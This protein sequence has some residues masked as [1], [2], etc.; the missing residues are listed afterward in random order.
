[1]AGH[2]PIVVA[3]VIGQKPT[4]APGVNPVAVTVRS[5]ADVVLSGKDS[6]ST[7]AAIKTFGWTKTGGPDLPVA[8]DTGALLYRTANTVSFRAPLV[9]PGAPPL[10]FRL[11]VT[12]AHG[13][14][15]TADVSVTVIPPADQNRTLLRP[16]LLRTFTVAVLTGDG[17]TGKQLTDDA[18][19]CVQLNRTLNYM[20][21]TAGMTGANP[22]VPPI[23]L[24]PIQVDTAWKKGTKVVSAGADGSAAGPAAK[25]YSNPR[26]T[27]ELPVLNDEEIFARFNQPGSTNRPDL[28]LVPADIDSAQL[29]VSLS[30]TAG[31]CAAGSGSSSAAASS[32]L[33]VAL[34]GNTGDVVLQSPPT[35]GSTTLI[36]DANAKPLTAD[37]L[38][39]AT[40]PRQN[41]KI[42]GHDTSFSGT[43]VETSAS[44]D[45]YYQAIDPTGSKKTLTAWL[46]A[47]CF[48]PTAA[49]YGVSK[50]GAG[51]GAHA[52]YTNN[53]DLGFGRD[54]YFI[55]CA[56][57][58]ANSSG[59]TAHAGDMATVV[60]NYASLEQ[61]ALK[62][63]PILAVAMEYSASA[64]GT[65]STRRF[66]KFYAFAPDD[67]TGELIRVRSAN[68]DRRGQKYLPGSCT[69]CHAGSLPSLPIAFSGPT[70][71]P[72]SCSANTY[73]LN[74]CYPLIQDPLTL[75]G[76]Q[77]PAHACAA[78]SPPGTPGCLPP[79]DVDAAFLPW[80]LDSFLFSD[81]DPAFKGTLLPGGPYTRAAQEPNLKALNQLAHATFK[82]G[83][84][85]TGGD[86]VQSV[87]P[88]GGG[89]TLVDRYAAAKTL[90]EY[91]YG[92]VSFPK[93][94]YADYTDTSP[95]EGWA[96]QP[97]PLYHKVFARNCRTCHL[98][99]TDTRLQFSGLNKAGLEANKLHDGYQK[100]VEEF[101]PSN[102]G[103][104]GKA[105][106]YIFQQGTMPLARL[107]MDRF[108]VDFDSGTG[109]ASAG[110][111]LATA[112][113]QT[114][115]LLGQPA[116]N[117]VQQQQTGTTPLTPGSNGNAGNSTDAR[118]DASGSGF[119]AKYSWA[120]A[121]S[122][123][124][125]FSSAATPPVLPDCSSGKGTSPL[126]LV[127]DT[128]PTPGFRITKSGLYRAT[129]TP[130]NGVGQSGAQSS[131]EYDICVPN[132][133]PAWTPTNKLCNTTPAAPYQSMTSP[134]PMGL[135][136]SECFSG[137]GNPPYTLG[138][139]GTA[140]NFMPSA[141]GP[142]TAW[143][144]SV[145]CSNVISGAPCDQ[146]D[147]QFNLNPGADP[148]TPVP[149]YFQLC[150]VDGDCT[151]GDAVA[152][153]PATLNVIP[154]S[155]KILPAQLV[156]YWAPCMNPQT[157][158]PNGSTPR[159]T[160][161]ATVM[162]LLHVPA[163]AAPIQ[164]QHPKVLKTPASPSVPT[165]PATAL[166]GTLLNTKMVVV[167]AGTSTL[168]VTIG[169][170]D[171]T[172]LNSLTGIS[173]TGLSAPGNALAAAV[174]QIIYEPP[175]RYGN[176]PFLDTRPYVTSDINGNALA[177]PPTPIPF[178]YTLS[179]GAGG[180][181]ACNVD[182][183][184]GSST[185][186]ANSV[187]IRALVSFNRPQT[188]VTN[189]KVFEVL[190]SSCGGCHNSPTSNSWEVATD[191]PG[192]YTSICG[193]TVTCD[194]PPPAI[195]DPNA[196]IVV[197]GDPDNSPFYT[198]ACLGTDT[199]MNA[200][201]TTPLS[202]TS[203]ECQ[204]IYQWI[205]EGAPND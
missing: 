186:P 129:L 9:A 52:V 192:T 175:S 68:F 30:A 13:V 104:P 167:G 198:A 80:D 166:L 140:G 40:A 105:Q 123:L 139:S 50:A 126:P 108:W 121:V 148:H 64:D 164:T 65:A 3:T 11:T 130:D 84:D 69:A 1:T 10:T 120:L 26:A 27:F 100:I 98:A 24:P 163:N 29:Q 188:G 125:N 204:T 60:I 176:H 113:Q 112:M 56:A 47:N 23:G 6:D 96:D 182:F 4:S 34:L 109:T 110:D 111:S 138:V 18:P 54:M 28:Q 124:L 118:I 79:G 174:G 161:P 189:T 31:T 153:T 37:T 137:F 147:V 203:V 95:P 197:R 15:G 48:D 46:S 193:G 194:A 17:L 89:T 33:I 199:L 90:T 63:S 70:T 43:A 41:Q 136:L 201:N 184:A 179:L 8:P 14:S 106:A 61:A 36:Q 169:S 162:S 7:D 196:K 82:Y 202:V 158:D 191:A 149:L 146:P 51:N 45:A 122:P 39:T 114:A 81:T 115:S 86:I 77:A 59:T 83:V 21:R 195:T 71:P 190:T 177:S 155:L 160:T 85:A 78:G 44:A 143:T 157:L 5:G 180:T 205:L 150:D 200:V 67:R 173:A 97:V 94:T 165:A 92:G 156:L 101:A 144:A 178:T 141:A 49:D 132:Y 131:Y 58:H 116:V 170:T 16:E 159:C 119:V 75:P 32:P 93:A 12:D 19:V 38:I 88:A 74:S 187:D 185:C 62:Q 22:S 35:V 20:T 117:A 134:L 72:G 91:W 102:T 66:T 127:G 42:A 168:T 87:I 128:G 152:G 183:G 76:Q 55:R 172:F 154:T 73:D 2:G 57:D 99:D 25:S 107:T 135:G 53:Y 103:Q 171:T 145:T 142:N 181:Q 151:P 133:Q